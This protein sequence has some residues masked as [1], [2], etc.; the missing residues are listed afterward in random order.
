MIWKAFELGSFLIEGTVSE[1]TEGPRK[2]TRISLK[3][4]GVKADFR[5]QYL[6]DITLQHY[7]HTN[8]SGGLFTCYCSILYFYSIRFKRCSPGHEAGPLIFFF[9]G[10]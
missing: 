2:T 9:W 5:T 10:T 3:M 1:L 4:A 7:R 6:P 8:L